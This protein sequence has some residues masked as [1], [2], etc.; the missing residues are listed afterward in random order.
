MRSLSKI[1]GAIGIIA[2]IALAASAA[3]ARSARVAPYANAYDS[4][5][6]GTQSIPYDA[7]G[8]AYGPGQRTID[9]SS[10]FQ[11]QGR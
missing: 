7:G 3:E 5:N 6:V 9:S 2:V 11:L 8:V 4:V 10:D 1:S